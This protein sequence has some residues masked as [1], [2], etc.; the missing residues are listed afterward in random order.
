MGNKS[1][2]TEELIASKTTQVTDKN[3][4][5]NPDVKIVENNTNPNIF[6]KLY[7][8]TFMKL[9]LFIFKYIMKGE[10]KGEENLDIFNKYIIALNHVSYLDWM[11][12]YSYFKFKKNIEITFLAKE[13]LF[14]S[15]IWKPLVICSKTIMVTNNRNISSM[16][17]LKNK[18][19]ESKII[20]IFPEGTRSLDGKIYAPQN[21]IA[22]IIQSTNTP[23]IP[24]GLKGFYEYWPRNKTLPSFFHKKNVKSEII[25][26]KPIISN[27]DI[28]IIDNKTKSESIMKTISTLTDIEYVP[29]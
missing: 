3:V 29:N 9:S 26:G 8:H 5:A 19:E 27:P 13:K 25:I 23:V 4:I 24:I 1:S 14:K 7:F 11:I 15:K 2:V 18:V 12:V 16:R 17:I 28:K 6:Y 20:G 22:H 21:G 10:V